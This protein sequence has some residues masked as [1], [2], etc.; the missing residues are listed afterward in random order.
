LLASAVARDEGRADRGPVAESATKQALADAE[1]NIEVE[2]IRVGRAQQGL[3][4]ALTQGAEGWAR[5]VEKAHAQADRRAG[6]LLTEL[7]SVERRRCELT[8]LGAWLDRY[9]RTGQAPR[10]FHVGAGSADVRDAVNAGASAQ[11]R[12]AHRGTDALHQQPWSDRR[13]S[14]R[15]GSPEDS[16]NRCRR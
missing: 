9:R 4:Q 15:V 5:A 11:R 8:A 6:E 2:R 10:K 14:R 1:R 12:R 13:Q 7:R 16:R 3:E